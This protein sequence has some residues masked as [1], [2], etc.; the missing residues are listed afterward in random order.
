M[1]EDECE[2]LENALNLIVCT[3]DRSGKM[4]KLLKQTIF[5]TVSTLRDL[6]M[7]LKT[8]RDR[9]TQSISDLERRVASMEAELAAF[10]D[11]TTKLQGRQLV[12]QH[13]DLLGST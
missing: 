11:T 6:F 7:Q 1:A 2:G 3:A 8:S 5:D 10:I 12:A 9:R 4:K 13:R